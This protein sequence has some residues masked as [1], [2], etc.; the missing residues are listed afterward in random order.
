MLVWYVTGVGFS[1]D[2]MIRFQFLKKFST[3]SFD[4]V[5]MGAVIGLLALGLTAIYS[6]DLSRD[7]RLNLFNKQLISL[8]VGG[9]LLI[10]LSLL[11]PT[12]YRS[13][14]KLAYVGSLI[15]LVAV[16]FF[17]REIRGTRGWFVVAGFSF[18]PV[19][20]AKL[21]L[22]LLLAYSSSRFGRRF[23]R[24]LYVIG[25]ACIAIVPALLTLRQPDVGSAMI[26]LIIWFGVMCLVG[27][28]PLHGAGIVGAGILAIIFAWFFLFNPLQKARFTS[29]LHPNEH[30]LGAAYNVNQ[31]MIAVGSGGLFG[32]GIGQGSQ[33]Q[34][35]FLPEAQTDFI[36]SVIA[37]E[38]GLVGATV[39]FVLSGVVLWR[40]FVILR[41]T[42][43]DFAAV[44]VGG[45][46]LL[47]FCQTL[48]NIGA[49][50]GILPLTGVTV[51]LVSYGG[52]SLIINLAM[53]GITE[54]MVPKK[55]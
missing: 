40:F 35:R 23:E 22:I 14:A 27:I 2:S 50:L 13:S 47:F 51:P 9:V 6:V 21:A 7:L 24:P 12:L 41:T 39:F 34:L 8:G 1:R 55:Y 3:R 45:F 36:F 32:K 26:L 29:F 46:A 54:S 33:S 25:T 19:E 20:Y 49:E 38:L 30:T 17:G 10:F 37:E 52:S 42:D 16:L 11:Q 44:T 5:L 18:Q 53:I 28:R 31:A 48:I 4:W 15:L 43:D